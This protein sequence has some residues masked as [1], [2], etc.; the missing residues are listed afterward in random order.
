LLAIP[1]I[2]LKLKAF[3]G[4]F[5]GLFLLLL[6]LGLAGMPIGGTNTWARLAGVASLVTAALLFWS[7][8]AAIRGLL[9]QMLAPPPK[10]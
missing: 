7:G 5:V 4:V 3:T 2:K 9:A 1:A 6:F 8:L 10:E